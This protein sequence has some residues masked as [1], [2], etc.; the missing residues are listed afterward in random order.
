MA[1]GRAYF[2]Y[3]SLMMVMAAEIRKR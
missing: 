2:F 1:K 3:L